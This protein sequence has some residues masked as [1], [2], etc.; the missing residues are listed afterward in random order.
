MCTR[1]G[2]TQTLELWSKQAEKFLKIQDAQALTKLI[3]V[4]NGKLFLN[5]NLLLNTSELKFN[6]S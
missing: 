3:S 5:T 1:R 6:S 4:Q 2:S